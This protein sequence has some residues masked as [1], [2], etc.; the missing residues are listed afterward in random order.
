VVSLGFL[1]VLILPEYRPFGP[2]DELLLA[3]ADAVPV[4]KLIFQRVRERLP[5]TPES[6]LPDDHGV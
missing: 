2:L 1:R 6:V 4:A 3:C 5:S